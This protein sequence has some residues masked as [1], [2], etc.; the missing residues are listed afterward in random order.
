MSVSLSPSIS[1]HIWTSI[2]MIVTIP[3]KQDPVQ[4]VLSPYLKDW[5]SLC[6]QEPN[7]LEEEFL[8]HTEE[9]VISHML[10]LKVI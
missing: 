3:S 2:G 10:H 9:R 8:S 5:E 1:S 6:D 7:W 4:Q